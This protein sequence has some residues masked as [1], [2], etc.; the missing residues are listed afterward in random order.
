MASQ[1]QLNP[2]CEAFDF[3][4]RCALPPCAARA[5]NIDEKLRARLFDSFSHIAEYAD[6][7]NGAT[8]LKLLE[9]R[10]SESSVSP[11]VFCLY[12]KLVAEI[13]KDTSDGV[14]PIVCDIAAAA[15]LPAEAGVVP[16]R[17]GELPSSWWDHF[18]VLFDTDSELP[19]NPQIASQP[20]LHQNGVTGL[21][22]CEFSPH[23]RAWGIVGCRQGHRQGFR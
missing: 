18:E 15:S 13:S 1:D 8:K 12:S 2:D 7:G 22:P 14:G 20:T 5:E 17:G 3:H 10:L 23:H 6:L 11:W 9:Q 4:K 16:F 21:S 19:F